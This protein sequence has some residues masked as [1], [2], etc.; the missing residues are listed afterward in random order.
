MNTPD[1]I[2][3]AEKA[4]LT[5]QPRL[6]E[7]YMRKASTLISAE[8]RLDALRRIG[9]SFS[10]MSVALSGLAGYAVRVA[11]Q[12]E[13]AM[14]KARALDAVPANLS[15]HYAQRRTLLLNGRKP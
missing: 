7:L 9:R 5:G 2:R 12:M 1:L 11:I 10:A 6:A 8:R 14:A 3:R 4:S 13:D 15:S